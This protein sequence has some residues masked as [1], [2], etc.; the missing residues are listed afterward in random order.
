[1]KNKW[2]YI[3]I[4]ALVGFY[5]VNAYNGLVK[6]KQEVKAKWSQI[7]VQLQR[8]NDLILS[9]VK[10]VKGYAKH[11][12]STLENVIA[13]RAKA[14]QI[15]VDPNKLDEA[16]MAKMAQAQG[17]LSQALGRL[18]MV[19]EAYP[20]LRANENFMMLQTEISGCENRLAVERKRYNEAA[21]EYNAGILTFPRNL[22]ASSFGFT[23][24]AY[25]QAE[26]GANKAPDFEF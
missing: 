22:I 18:M 19:S 2:I 4:A 13:A 8:R 11:E 7:E 24:T 21:K 16:S 23:E 14:T 25:Y 12:S 17:E 1:M 26:A 15:T 6:Q 5:L 10:T 20:E 3:A 9:L